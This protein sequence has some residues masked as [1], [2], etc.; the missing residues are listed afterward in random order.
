[1]YV[2][3]F[4]YMRGRK[5]GIGDWQPAG[6]ARREAAGRRRSGGVQPPDLLCPASTSGI[7]IQW[8]CNSNPTIQALH[9]MGIQLS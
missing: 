1:M 8:P 5:P 2:S 6:G 3:I 7:A 9:I 4:I